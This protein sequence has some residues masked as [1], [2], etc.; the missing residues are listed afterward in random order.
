MTSNIGSDILLSAPE[1]T[2]TVKKDV[3]KL[4]HQIFRPEF[5][6]RIDAIVFFKRLEQPDIERIAQ[7]QLS[8]LVHRMK[9]RHITLTIDKN[10]VKH[11]A[12]LGYSP[13]FGARPLK[14]VIQQSVVVP[15]SQ[16]VLKNPESKAVSVVLDNDVISVEATQAAV[17]KPAKKMAKGAQ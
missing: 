5:L 1:I 12:E 11:L 13:E 10:A 4:L 14:R 15:L 6:N 9:E 7:I 8:D 16:Y 17:D 2:P 3:E